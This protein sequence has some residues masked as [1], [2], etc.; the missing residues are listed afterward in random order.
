LVLKGL[1]Q[2]AGGGANGLA[3]IFTSYV[4][5]GMV[6]ER[7]WIY[8]VTAMPATDRVMVLGLV[9]LRIC[10][11]VLADMNKAGELGKFNATGEWQEVNPVLSQL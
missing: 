3:G 1:R 10:E 8:R 2:Y 6:S 9:W 11:K 4:Q 7:F 5:V